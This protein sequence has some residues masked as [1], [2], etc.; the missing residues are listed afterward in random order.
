MH[1]YYL[2]TCI[3]LYVSTVDFYFYLLTTKH[4]HAPVYLSF[5]QVAIS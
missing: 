4:T 3:N 5:Y 2:H 1:M